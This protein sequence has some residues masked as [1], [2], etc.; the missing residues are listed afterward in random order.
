M[1]TYPRL[2]ISLCTAR[3]DDDLTGSEPREARPT[4][5]LQDQMNPVDGIESLGLDLG[6][7]LSL[8]Q[9]VV[10]LHQQLRTL[11]LRCRSLHTLGNG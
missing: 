1:F 9:L 3:Y 7:E 6:I 8:N 10:A 11:N 5:M 2:G 4:A